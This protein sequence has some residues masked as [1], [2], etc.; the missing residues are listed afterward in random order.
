MFQFH[1]GLIKSRIK[2]TFKMLSQMFQFHSGLI[3]RRRPGNI[4]PCP[5]KVSIP[6]WAD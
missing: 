1:S 2:V 4:K 5:K 3:K 6:L